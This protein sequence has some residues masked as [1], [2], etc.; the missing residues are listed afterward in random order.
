MTCNYE[1]VYSEGF[2][3]FAKITYDQDVSLY[4]ESE[5]ADLFFSNVSLDETT[6]NA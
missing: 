1:W 3:E 6:I 5:D 2:L 4:L